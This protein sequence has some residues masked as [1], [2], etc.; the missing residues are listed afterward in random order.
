MDEGPRMD[1]VGKDSR[2]KTMCSIILWSADALAKSI[3][4]R[5]AIH[6][7]LYFSLFEWF[8]PLYLND[9]QNKFATRD[10]VEVL[11]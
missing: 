7:G 9:K 5:T 8:N 10:Y 6:F 2:S 11:D 1:L 3:R 4:S